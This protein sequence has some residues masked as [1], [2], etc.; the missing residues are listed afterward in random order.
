MAADKKH[1]H[2]GVLLLQI[3][4]IYSSGI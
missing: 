3:D 4:Y 2:L 1:L